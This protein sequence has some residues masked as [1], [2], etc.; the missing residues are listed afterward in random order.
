MNTLGRVD[1]KRGENEAD[2]YY[3]QRGL[4]GYDRGYAGDGG[5]A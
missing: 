5:P 2:K 1:W 4:E 3:Y